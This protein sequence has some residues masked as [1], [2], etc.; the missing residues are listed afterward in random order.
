[1][2]NQP[3]LKT[4]LFLSLGILTSQSGSVPFRA[5][6]IVVVLIVLCLLLLYYLKST[7]LFFQL[8][9]LFSI[10]LLGYLRAYQKTNL[11]PSDHIIHFVP[12]EE[13]VHIRG[14]LLKDSVDKNRRTEFWV[15]VDSIRIGNRR[16]KSCGGVLVSSYADLPISLKYGDEIIVFG[17]LERPAGQRNPGGFDYRD[18]LERKGIYA[19][20]RIKEP[21][22]IQRTGN[23]KGNW[24]LRKWIYPARRYILRVIDRTTVGQSRA[25]LKA[26][27]V[28]ERGEISPEVRDDFAKAGVIHV[29]AVSGLH[30]G[31]VVLIFLTIFGLLRFPYLLRILLTIAGLIFYVLLTEAK[32]P[33]TRASIMCGL[34]LLGTTLERRP[35]PF[36]IMGLA[37]LILL[38]IHPSDL[39]DLG[40]QLSF[41]AVFSIVYFYQKIGSLPFVLKIKNRLFKHPFGQSVFLAFLVSLSAQLG[42]LPLIAGY[43]NRIPLLALVI[44]LI[45]VPTAGLIVALGFTSIIFSLFSFWIASVYGVLNQ[46]I[47]RLFIGLIQWFGK[48]SF[49]YIEIPNPGIT[50]ILLY[51]SLLLF[52]IHIYDSKRRKQFFFAM[53]I[54]ANL[55][56]WEQ[57]LRNDSNKLTWIQFDVGQGDAA[58]IRL[59]RGK[60]VLI[61]GGEKRPHFDNGERVIAPCLRKQGIRK[62]DLVILTHPHNDHVG[63]L[64]YILNHF[65]VMSVITAG[66]AFDSGLY[67]NFLNAIE[68]RCIPHR[69]VTA[70][71]SLFFP[72][73]KMFF[74]SPVREI[75]N[76]DHNVN[77]QSIVVRIAYGG[78][79]L[80]FMGD[81]ERAIENDLVSQKRCLHSDGLKIG[82]H[83]SITSSTR[84]FLERVAPEFAVISVGQYNRFGHPSDVVIHRLRDINA[85]IFRTDHGGAVIFRTDGK[86]LK[87]IDW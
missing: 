75:K 23:K 50:L 87:K 29:L 83:G 25:L 77:N 48:L 84:S 41:A 20:L 6:W 86:T 70:P 43:F 4:A 9:L 12:S 13:P 11:F 10:F 46:E 14:V 33:V 31:F 54:F 19:I 56:I 76:S 17:S 61:D 36:N 28:G 63:G 5:V 49:S 44:N 73:I 45:A 81:A 82:H 59:P 80:L 55:W 15:A 53:M 62:L 78:I 24:L 22:A 26:L 74:L 16:I 71:D 65:H 27:I 32:A 72:G 47:I 60:T 21:F 8:L 79:R 34:Y 37:G 2:R 64:T 68:K 40:F 58:L 52:L 57:V 38:L 3:A 30:V 7:T 42:T 18:Y 69:V 39:F 35:N 1:M 51:F 85:D 67:R 66:T